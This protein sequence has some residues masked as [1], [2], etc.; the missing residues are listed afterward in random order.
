MKIPRVQRK[1]SEGI[2]SGFKDSDQL[3]V[4][5]ANDHMPQ[6]QLFTK[7]SEGEN[8]LLCAECGSKLMYL[9]SK[10]QYLCTYFQCGKIIDAVASTPLTK[11]NQAMQPFQSQH[12]DPNNLDDEPFFVS[13]NPDKGDVTLEKDYEITHSSSDGR[14]KHIRCKGYPSDISI[15]AFDD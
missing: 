12:Y 4:D 6:K 9:N 8:L 3:A 2:R 5:K 7:Q 15:N 13:F 14:V 1:S 11:T 10:Q